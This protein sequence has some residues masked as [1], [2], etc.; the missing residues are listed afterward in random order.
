MHIHFKNRVLFYFLLLICSRTAL[1][2]DHSFSQFW[3]NRTYYNPAFVGL[4][5]GELNGL[6]TYKKL[7]PKFPGNFSTIHF[8]ADMKTYNS[9]GFGL[10]I[11]SSDEGSGFIKS[12]T[13]GISYSWREYFNKEKNIYFQ[14]GVEGSYNDERLDF[15]KYIYSGNLHEIYGNIIPTTQSLGENIN[16]KQHYW[17][18]SAGCMVY[19]PWERH[20]REFMHNFIGFSIH[21]L[22][23][24][25]DNFIEDDARIPM[26]ISLQ[27]NSFI[28]T[29]LYSLDRKS[30]LYICP[31]LLFEN[32][33]DQLMSSSSFNN[34][35]V[36]ADLTT[37]P[38]FGGFWYSSKL[39]N[40]SK[41]KTGYKI[42]F[43]K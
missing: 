21:H 3:E 20:Y 8:S 14:L 36:V 34:V 4:N 9:Y 29:D 11:L 43:I 24:P 16:E 30:S 1:A 26:K 22:T 39:L 41:E 17:D 40:S 7:W 38:L 19:I 6:L 18:F 13:V 42:K 33:G 10:Y 23:R 31:G 32:Q 12:N 35:V 25:K 37:D 27:W 5:V 28:R 15:N 2:Q